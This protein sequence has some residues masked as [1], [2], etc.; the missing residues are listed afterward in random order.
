M[1]QVGFPGH[2]TSEQWATFLVEFNKRVGT[3][4][5]VKEFK[6]ELWKI[7]IEYVEHVLIGTGLDRDT[8]EK[9]LKKMVHTRETRHEIIL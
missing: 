5:D 4:M 7:V 3:K 1:K 6:K 9:L 8:T 2:Q